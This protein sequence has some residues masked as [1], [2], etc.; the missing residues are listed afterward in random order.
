MTEGRG[1][2]GAAARL[3]VRLRYLVVGAWVAAAVVLTM[4][5]P[6]IGEAQ[7]GALG[8][9][10]PNQADA[11]DAELRSAELF[12][13]P[14]LSRTL[15]VQRNPKGLSALEQARAVARAQAVSSNNLPGLERI[16]GALPIIN[17]L[18]RPPFSRESSTT[19]V[20]YLF[21]PQSVDPG[22]RA[23]LAERYGRLYVMPAKGDAF[24]G[25]TGVLGARAQQADIITAKLPLVE[26]GT[27]LLVTLV[28]GL[29][30]RAVGAP[31]ATLAAVGVSYLV[32]TRLI[33]AIARGLGVSVP[34][35]VEPVIVVLLFGVVTD[36][37][38]FFLSRVR[39]RPGRRRGACGGSHTGHGGAAAHHRDRGPD[40]RGGQR[41][42]DR[43]QAR[44][45]PVLRAGDG[46]GRTRWDAGV[47]ELRPR[48]AGGGR[49]LAVLAAATGDR[50]FSRADGRGDPHRAHR[51]AE[52]LSGRQ[53][54][55]PAPAGGD[56]RLRTGARS[57]GAGG[58]AAR[59]GQP[60]D[61]RPARGLAGP[62]GLRGRQQGLYPR[63]PLSHRARARA[64]GPAARENRLARLRRLRPLVDQRRDLATLQRLVEN[65]PGVAQVV[66]PAEQ[67]AANPFGAVLSRTG[68]A[69][70]LFVV[71][72][73]DPLGPAAIQSLR[74]L[75]AR[76]PLLLEVAGLPRVRASVAGDT[77]LIAETIDKTVSDLG[78]IA[79]VALGV[80]LLVLILFLRALVAPLYLV[81]SS[82]LA[83]MASLGLATIFFHDIL[84][85]GGLT[86]YVPFA[87]A[88]LLVSLGSDYN[89]FLVGRIWAEARERPLREAVAVAGARAAT[90]IT[91]AG[92]VLAASFALLVLVPLLP[93][94]QLAFTVAVGLALDAFLV[95]TLM[96][97]A[98]MALVGPVS[99]WPGRRLRRASA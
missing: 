34:Q 64:P 29:H 81:A 11:L 38:I 67:P 97:P 98:L 49:A 60:G 33:A 40:R 9:L 79:P 72:D 42:A 12:R 2:A 58:V 4:T 48:P 61:P 8:D 73:S 30:F 69:A 84:G 25:V 59:G 57:G 71:F 13:F 22:D 24:V 92:L 14:L 47:G 80:V 53:P 78:R 56:A 20:T 99:G 50:G 66:G 46:H 70:R 82:V 26:L 94:R 77:A 63:H 6:T 23:A 5:L 54:G 65:Q 52:A 89:V 85:Y 21:F 41:L 90:P 17:T 19:A 35:E 15:V 32:S 95:R 1:V 68:G 88:V 75:R 28:V 86:Y 55:H 27:V 62:R 16:G 93:F 96:V 10:V 76:L 43:R 31:L 39:R 36:Y 45:L 37:S 18:G 51:A 87:A 3:L 83:L 91:I 74:S 7:T 44:L